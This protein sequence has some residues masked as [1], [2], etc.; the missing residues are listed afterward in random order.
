MAYSDL[1]LL[2]L[3]SFVGYIANWRL[4]ESPSV[5]S[6]VVLRSFCLVGIQAYTATD[7]GLYYRTLYST[8]V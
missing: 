8:C 7:A 2:A 4:S 6:D 5:N 1:R 3:Y